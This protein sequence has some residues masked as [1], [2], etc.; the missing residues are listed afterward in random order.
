[1]SQK[2]QYKYLNEQEQAKLLTTL[3][4]RRSAN[5]DY[6]LIHLALKTGLRVAELRG[7]NISDI[8][9]GKDVKKTLIVR[10]EIAKG[11]KQRKVALNADIRKHLQK[12][13]SYKKKAKESLADDSPLFVSRNKNRISTDA[14]QDLT[15][16]WCKEANLEEN[17]TPHSFRHTFGT[18]LYRATANLRLVQ[19]ILGHSSIKTTQI[20]THIL[21]EDMAEAVEMI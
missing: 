8:Y 14:V 3:K 10:E 13:Y 2:K 20:Y 15:R 6:M 19:T 12:F 21:K 18:R 17:H 9:I 16:K 7:L 5:R 1:M 11:K 4:D